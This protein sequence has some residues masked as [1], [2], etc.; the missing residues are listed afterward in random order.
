MAP[1]VNL[2]KCIN[3]E[4]LQVAAKRRIPKVV[5]DFIEG[6]VDGEDGLARNEDAFRKR[7]L[8]PRYMVD[9][10]ARD[11]SAELFGRRYAS[12]FGIAPTGGIG[13]F[14]RGADLMLAAAARDADV[15]FI[16]SG[17]ATASME[18][19]ARIAPDHGWY[20]VYIAKDRAI[21]EDMVRRAD[22]L[23]LNAL[24]ITV[25]VPA[26]VNRERNRRNGFGRPLKLS[27]ASRLNA[28][29]H[30]AWLYDYLRY[31]IADLPN[32]APYVGGS[33]TPVEV[34]EFAAGQTPGPVH[35]S[36]IERLRE[37][38]P[39]K[40]IVKGVMRA[41][42]A[43]RLAD[44]GVDGIMVSNHGARQLDRAPSPLDVLPSI[45]A[46]V[47]DR[48]TLMLDGGVRRG[49][50]VLTA[51]CMGAKFVFLGRPTLYG[52]V[53]GGQAGA[54]HALSI[55]RNEV[56]LVMAQLG[57]T[58]LMQLGRDFVEWDADELARNRM[59]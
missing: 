37:L 39:R 47:G 49:A 20:Q 32:W 34:V 23:N 57:V 7:P 36:D 55:V 51:F 46:A 17:T 53:A 9:I 56:D 54:A 3:L 29:K 30:P 16:M 38:W 6:G 14:R 12:A 48:L 59:R 43:V 40:L 27:L 28:L 45:D 22:A 26:R 1:L 50:D 33:P 25:D 18:D 11:Q 10:S 24:V 8:M 15:P 5:Y 21:T 42:D 13:N 2:Q 41:D 4:D 35:F 58:A 52:A 19:M 44:A 31:G